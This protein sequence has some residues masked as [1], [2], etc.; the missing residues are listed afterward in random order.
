MIAIFSIVPSAKFPQLMFK[1]ADLEGVTHY[2]EFFYFPDSRNGWG[3][4]RSSAWF[5]RSIIDAIELQGYW[6]EGQMYY[7]AVCAL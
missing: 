1:S 7:V 2:Q 5:A 3:N 4:M 6:E